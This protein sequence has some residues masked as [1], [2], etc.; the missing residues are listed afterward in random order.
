MDEWSSKDQ[1]KHGQDALSVPVAV[2]QLP[3]KATWDESGK[4]PQQARNDTKETWNKG[5][6]S[7]GRML[8]HRKYIYNNSLLPV[9][10]LVEWAMPVADSVGIPCAQICFYTMDTIIDTKL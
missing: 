9:L 6:W 7:D 8:Q 5:K 10:N 4:E 1:L 3:K 2:Q